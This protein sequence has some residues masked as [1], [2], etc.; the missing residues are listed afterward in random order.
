MEL[1]QHW[2]GMIK[3]YLR[4]LKGFVARVTGHHMAQRRFVLMATYLA[5]F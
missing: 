1:W 4:C 5:L 3:K 2:M